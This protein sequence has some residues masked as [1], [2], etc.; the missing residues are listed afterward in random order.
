VTPFPVRFA[1]SGADRWEGHS[2]DTK[3]EWN[4]DRFEAFGAE[5]LDGA[6]RLDLVVDAAELH[7]GTTIFPVSVCRSP[8]TTAS[9]T[10]AHSSSMPRSPQKHFLPA[11][12]DQFR[13]T[14]QEANVIAVQFHAVGR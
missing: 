10:M 6:A 8:Y 1:V 2:A 12:V 13:I 5:M 9:S 4:L 3:L 7:V 14:R 11:H